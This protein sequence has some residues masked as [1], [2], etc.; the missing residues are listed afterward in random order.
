MKLKLTPKYQ[1]GGGFPPLTSVYT[2]VTVTNPYTSP[3]L[4]GLAQAAQTATTTTTSTNKEIDDAT[5]LLD[6]IEGLD[7]DVK[8]ISS[9]LAQVSKKDELF[10][11]QD[12]TQD[13]YRN[14]A[15]INQAKQSKEEYKE[16]YDQIKSKNGLQDIATTTDGK[17]VVKLK[18]SMQ[19]DSVSPTEFFQNQNKYTALTNSNLLY[20]RAHNMNYAQNDTITS[21]VSQGTSLTEI[22]KIIKDLSD[23][24]GS[25]EIS[26][27]SYIQKNQ[28]QFAKGIAV[29]KQIGEKIADQEMPMDGLYKI[30]YEN[31]SNAAAAQLAISEIWGNLT[32]A[33][34]ALLQFQ[35]GGSEKKA[36]SLIAEMVAKGVTSETKFNAD[37]QYQLETD[38]SKRGSNTGGNGL[39]KSKLSPQDLLLRGLAYS[40]DE[41][42]NPGSSAYEFHAKAFYSSL[43]GD[44]LGQGTNLTQLNKLSKWDSLLDSG[45]FSMG[46]VPIKNSA[47][48][49]VILGDSQFRVVELPYT[50]VDGHIVPDMSKCKAMEALDIQLRNAGIQDTKGNE[51]KVNNY[52]IQHHLSP[53]YKNSAG[54]WILN[55]GNYIKFAVFDGYSDESAFVNNDNVNIDKTL[56]KVDG[57]DENVYKGWVQQ[58]NPA[59]KKTFNINGDVYHG[60]IFVPMNNNPFASNILNSATF[61]PTAAN[62]NMLEAQYQAREKYKN[63]KRAGNISSY[64]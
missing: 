58:S 61:A 36:Q 33:Q 38:G 48:G 26:N 17:I 15:L 39:D 2:P 4:T 31:K 47:F 28:G 59:L 51:A 11:T 24:L 41:I 5:K 53:K 3:F 1:S 8:N 55:T 64:Q 18:N 25:T 34:K 56:V 29:L 54:Q 19:I 35:V 27:T 40:K 63:F 62:A 10:G 44:K 13:Y 9:V 42:F 12:L 22:Q 30:T 20:E 49:K 43:A 60:S 6:H 21:I 46:G 16:A 45:N 57:E 7:N 14:I 37:Y 52:C 23:N 50:T 32:S